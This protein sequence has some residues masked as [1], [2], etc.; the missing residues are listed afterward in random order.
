MS[1]NQATNSDT[2]KSKTAARTQR[3]R[4]KPPFYFKIILLLGA[5]FFALVFAEI[6]VRVIL[7]Q[8]L[9]GVMYAA[10]PYFGF[11]NKANLE[12]KQ[13]HSDAHTPPYRVT[14]NAQGYRMKDPVPTP[15]P[16]DLVRVVVVGDSFVYGVGLANEDTF[17][18]QMEAILRADP[19]F[20]SG[21]RIQVVNAGCPGWGTENAIAFL[22]KRIEE[23]EPDLVIYAM[24]RNDL[25]DNMRRLVFQ[26]EDDQLIH[27]PNKKYNRFKRI[28]DS[29]PFYT[30]FSEH[31]QLLNLV[32]RVVSNMV[33]QPARKFELPETTRKKED[34]KTKPTPIPTPTPT[35]RPGARIV[36][37]P[38]ESGPDIPLYLV[39]HLDTFNL[40][41]EEFMRLTDKVGAT[42]FFVMLPGLY[43]CEEKPII[44][45]AAAQAYG[46]KWENEGRLPFLSLRSVF[47]DLEEPSHYFIPSDGHYNANG[48]ELVARELAPRVRE[49]LKERFRKED[50]PRP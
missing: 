31:S 33:T 5:L 38:L 46:E 15:K 3:K 11:W 4:R 12:S 13:F 50:S 34:E 37:H 18:H 7:P 41:M 1:E 22:Q 49:I 32:R 19:D 8:P 10:D 9:S 27:A 35:P 28:A 47:L 30:F 44:Q 6:A 2:K 23:L 21:R 14:T 40:L 39:R 42:R 20:L 48:H 43:D 17:C 25:K 45:Y 36:S 16:D 24:Y 29:I 26:V